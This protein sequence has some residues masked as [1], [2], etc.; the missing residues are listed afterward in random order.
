LSD[1]LYGTPGS[2]QHLRKETV[3]FMRENQTDFEQFHKNGPIDRHLDLLEED[4]TYA[5]TKGCKQ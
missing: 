4:A 2:Y 3:H 5:G 1:Q